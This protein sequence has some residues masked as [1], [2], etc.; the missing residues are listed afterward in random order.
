MSAADI[1][2]GWWFVPGRPQVLAARD[3]HVQ[4]L[5]QR[6]LVGRMPPFPSIP[7]NG[8]P[9][10]IEEVLG[11]WRAK[12]RTAR[13]PVPP[14][15]GSVLVPAPRFTA[16]EPEGEHI[17]PWLYLVAKRARKALALLRRVAEAAGG[18]E[19][20]R[21]RWVAQHYFRVGPPVEG[22]TAAYIRD[23][24]PV[25]MAEREL[26][27]AKHPALRAIAR[28]DLA[29]A[30]SEAERT[31]KG[32]SELA[33]FC[34]GKAES[35]QVQALAVQFVAMYGPLILDFGV[36]CYDDAYGAFVSRHWVSALHLHSPLRFLGSERHLWPAGW[37]KWATTAYRTVGRQIEPTKTIPPPVGFYVWAAY[38]LTALREHPEWPGCQL[39]LANRMASLRL[40]PMA[41]F[42]QLAERTERPRGP[43]VSARLYGELLDHLALAAAYQRGARIA[44]TATQCRNCEVWFTID[45]R[46]RKYCDDCNEPKIR[47]AARARLY[48]ERHPNPVT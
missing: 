6:V 28:E 25:V 27:E 36:W 47:D 14:R 20:S 24:N 3:Y 31:A 17:E 16:Q 30:L 34:L 12:L 15:N 18:I 43:R 4:Y 2:P 41:W 8:T 32:E 26:K 35:A 46:R 22:S 10:K 37:T 38:M 7:E 42:P 21:L 19:E 1:Q 44:E 33:A 11:P 40:A 29:F 9:E 13:L 23:Q 45:D 5:P 39:F 48:R